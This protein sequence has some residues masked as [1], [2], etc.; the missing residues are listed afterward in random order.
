MVNFLQPILLPGEEDRGLPLLRESPLSLDPTSPP[1][2]ISKLCQRKKKGR[3]NAQDFKIQN[4]FSGVAQSLPPMFATH[5]QW[6]VKEGVNK[7]KPFSLGLCP[8]HRTPPTYRARLRQS[9][10]KN[11]FF[12]YNLWGL[13]ASWNGQ[14]WPPHL[15][16]TCFRTFLDICSKTNWMVIFTK[17]FGTLDPP[18]DPP[19]HSLGQSPK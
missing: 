17:K 7:K 19:T 6:Q 14:I 2:F 1:R 4:L 10:K 11:G 15:C 12:F 8:K 9:L 18:L 16:I 13:K 5:L 3:E